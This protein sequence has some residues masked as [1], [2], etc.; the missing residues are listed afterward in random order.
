M[1]LLPRVEGCGPDTRGLNRRYEGGDRNKLRRLLA[2]LSVVGVGCAVLSGFAASA[3]ANELEVRNDPVAELRDYVQLV[4]AA[5]PDTA[6]AADTNQAPASVAHVASNNDG[7][8]ALRAFVQRV[9]ADPSQSSAKRLKVAEA[10]NA[11]DALREFFQ[12][13]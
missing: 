1:R 7:Y 4:A 2:V 6:A 11:F 5:Q 3:R 10:D 9:P 12:K 8:A 13:Q